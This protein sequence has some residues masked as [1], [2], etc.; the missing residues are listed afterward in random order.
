M[1]AIGRTEETVLSWVKLYRLTHTQPSVALSRDPNE[2]LNILQKESSLL[3]TVA[4]LFAEEI[5]RSSVSL[6]KLSMCRVGTRY[7]LRSLVGDKVIYWDAGICATGY[8]NDT[9]DESIEPMELDEVMTMLL[10][11]KERPVSV[12]ALWIKLL[13][14]SAMNNYHFSSLTDVEYV[15]IAVKNLLHINLPPLPVKGK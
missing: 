7:I 11:G 14:S 6:G 4:L 8:I 12:L 2:M 15:S 13:N 1:S 3:S 10:T 9:T 5:T